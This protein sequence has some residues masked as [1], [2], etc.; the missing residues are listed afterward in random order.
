V[1]IAISAQG[2]RDLCRQ[3]AGLDLAGK[4]FCLCMKG[5][6]AQTG[7]RLSQVFREEVTAPI[8]LAIW[9]GPGHVQEFLRSVPNCMVI[10]SDDAAVTGRVVDQFGGPLI[11]LYYGQDLAGSEVGAASKNVIGLAAGMLDGLGLASLKGALMA[12]G[13]RE[14][15]RLIRAMGGQELTAYGLAHLGDY[16]ATLFSP[17]SHNRRFGE[18][19]VKGQQYPELAEGVPTARALQ[20]LAATLHVDLPIC[21]AVSRVIEE[22]CDPKAVL[23]E[24]F[25]RPRTRQF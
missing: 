25:L 4:T 20:T 19:F 13:A 22:H 5:L 21:N 8:D 15:S 12:R 11:R 10:D 16:E 23:E 1:I 9:V 7:K 14:I 6:E 3:L 2:L 17:H 24:L 18:M